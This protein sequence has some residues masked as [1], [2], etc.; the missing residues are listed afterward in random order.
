MWVE[1]IP[2]RADFCGCPGCS[3]CYDWATDEGVKIPG[4]IKVGQEL[5]GKKRVTKKQ[6]AAIRK[7]ARAAH[8]RLKK[9]PKVKP[10]SDAE[11]LAAYDERM[12]KQLQ[13]AQ[14]KKIRMSNKP[15]SPIS[16]RTVL[17][18]H[19]EI[20]LPPPMPTGNAK[21]ENGQGSRILK[22]FVMSDG[23]TQWR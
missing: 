8:A 19:I 5:T 17:L 7:G 23:S 4:I 6:Q 21:W 14:F 3:L 15:A 11:L 18:D 16:K 2:R 22:E 20:K 1:K 10:L 13:A 9:P 12:E